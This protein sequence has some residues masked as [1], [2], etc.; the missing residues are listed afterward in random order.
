LT[1]ASI[2]EAT[3]LGRAASNTER[4]FCD[5]SVGREPDMVEAGPLDTSDVDPDNVS[6]CP[7]AMGRSPGLAVD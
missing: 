3:S 5:A 6:S 2:D 7:T 1:P 4:A